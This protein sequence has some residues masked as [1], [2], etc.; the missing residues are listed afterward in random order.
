MVEPLNGQPRA[1]GLVAE[2]F[3]QERYKMRAFLNRLFVV[4]VLAN[5]RA[6]FIARHRADINVVFHKSPLSE[7]L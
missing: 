3:A 1:F 5:L 6:I 7:K 2:R 4:I